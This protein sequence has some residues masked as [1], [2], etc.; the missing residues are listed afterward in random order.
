M[1]VNDKV[2]D[3]VMEYQEILKLIKE[4]DE[5]TAVVILEKLNSLEI[6]IA[7]IKEELMK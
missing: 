3:V 5:N 6:K 2:N 4:L 7:D 1:K